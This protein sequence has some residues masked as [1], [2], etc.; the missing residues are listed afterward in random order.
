LPGLGQSDQQARA[1]QSYTRLT[2]EKPHDPQTLVPDSQF[3]PGLH[4][5]E[6]PPDFTENACFISRSLG[7]AWAFCEFR[8]EFEGTL[9]YLILGSD[10]APKTA[11]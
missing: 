1:S 5:S 11:P 10:S 9:I 7:A 3:R 6:I 2:S 8:G 4:G